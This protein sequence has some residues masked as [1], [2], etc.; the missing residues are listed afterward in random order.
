MFELGDLFLQFFQSALDLSEGLILARTSV[1]LYTLQVVVS[2]QQLPQTVV[3]LRNLFCRWYVLIDGIRIPLVQ[4]CGGAVAHDQ[5]ADPESDVSTKLQ[6]TG[7]F[8]KRR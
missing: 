4:D 1:L 7:L 5:I 6:Q 8:V 2:C 3:E